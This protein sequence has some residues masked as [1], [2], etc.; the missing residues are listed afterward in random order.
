MRRASAMPGF[1][2]R[3]LGTGL[4]QRF[5]KAQIDR[6]LPSGPTA[7]QRAQGRAVVV[8]EAWNAAGQSVVSRLV[9][10]EPYALT[11]LTAV[12]IMHRIANG[13]AIPGFQTPSA[14]FGAH[15]ILRFPDVQRTDL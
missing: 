12:E 9:T 10:P 13:E 5:L 6:R 8:A 11:A 2:K 1:V 14:M 4:A 15:F 7:E 3:A